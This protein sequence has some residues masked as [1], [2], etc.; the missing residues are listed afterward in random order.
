MCL[1]DNFGAPR[2][3]AA[4]KRTLIFDPPAILTVHLK[5]FRQVCQNNALYAVYV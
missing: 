5:R 2:M 4:K 1:L 3:T